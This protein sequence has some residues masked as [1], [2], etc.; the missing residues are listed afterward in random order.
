MNLELVAQN[1][2]GSS[3]YERDR[4]IIHY[5]FEGIVD[6]EKAK[7]I[8]TETLK[9]SEKN[10]ILAIHADIRGLRGTFSMFDEYFSKEYFPLLRK[11]GLRVHSMVLPT[12]IFTKY[13]A[14]RIQQKS[15]IHKKDE[16]ELRNFDDLNE[17]YN[18]IL[19]N[20]K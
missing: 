2:F 9:F 1:E 12:D 7:E 8:F 3:Q 14:E 15:K 13:A 19:E 6:V 17:A 10:K 18:W 5:K 11:R 16:F 4:K 20:L